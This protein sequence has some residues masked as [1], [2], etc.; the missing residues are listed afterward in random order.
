M[1]GLLLFW[2]VYSAISAHLFRQNFNQVLH[3]DAYTYL[4]LCILT[5]AL[6]QFI[7]FFPRYFSSV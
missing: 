2:F 3:A 1:I 6:L 7:P 5:I 4:P